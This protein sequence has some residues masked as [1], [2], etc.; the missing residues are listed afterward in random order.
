MSKLDIAGKV[1]VRRLFIDDHD[2]VDDNDDDDDDNDD[3]DDDEVCVQ[4]QVAGGF[5]MR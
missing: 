1:C 5:L 4:R 2:E 3:D